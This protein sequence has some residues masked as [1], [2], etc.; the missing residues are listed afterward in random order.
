[1][2]RSAER[3]ER[4]RH[5]GVKPSRALAPQWGRSV[6]TLAVYY[7]GA[8]FFVNVHPIFSRGQVSR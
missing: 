1:M 6:P 3:S 4:T 5:R 7:Y 8:P 2:M